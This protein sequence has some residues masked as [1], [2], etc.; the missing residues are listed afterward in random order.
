MNDD[1]LTFAIKSVI[2]LNTQVTKLITYMTQ[3]NVPHKSTILRN[4][5]D[6][7]SQSE[8]TRCNVYKT[9]NI[10]LEVHDVYVKRRVINDLHRI[11]FTRFRV[12]GHSLAVETGRWNRRGRGRLPLEERLC[13]C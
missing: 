7:I 5:H 2:S 12:C 13:T 1:P 10:N 6:A 11:S 8:T 4:V 3:N 9:M